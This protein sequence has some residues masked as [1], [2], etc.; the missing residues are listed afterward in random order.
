VSHASAKTRRARLPSEYLCT[1]FKITRLCSSIES[2]RPLL[3]LLFVDFAPSPFTQLPARIVRDLLFTTPP[4]HHRIKLLSQLSSAAALLT[5]LCTNCNHPL[6]LC[7]ELLPQDREAVLESEPP[8]PQI[9]L[10]SAH[11]P[12]C[13]SIRHQ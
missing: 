4:L 11:L 12:A 9:Q 10:P 6:P 2:L 13:R 3:L 8:R 7:Q 5:Q 1:R